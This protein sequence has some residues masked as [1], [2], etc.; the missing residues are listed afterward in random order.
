MHASNTDHGMAIA[1]M[2]VDLK[3]VLFSNI[4]CH[5]ATYLS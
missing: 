3:V 1:C 5:I 4:H 2:W